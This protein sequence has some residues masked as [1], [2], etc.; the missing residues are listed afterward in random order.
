MDNSAQASQ[1]SFRKCQ[2]TCLQAAALTLPL[3]AYHNVDVPTALSEASGDSDGFPRPPC[4]LT[5]LHGD[6]TCFFLH[7]TPAFPRAETSLPHSPTST[8]FAMPHFAPSTM[9]PGWNACLQV[10]SSEM[11]VDLICFQIISPGSS[12]AG[13]GLGHRLL[14]SEKCLR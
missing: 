6:S 4:V 2:L 7:V 5:V 14:R 11:T 8:F 10:F 1:C 3:T 13:E 9:S 12:A